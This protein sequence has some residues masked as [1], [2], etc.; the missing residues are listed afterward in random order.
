MTSFSTKAD[1]C[2]L[3]VYCNSFPL[4]TTQEYILQQPS[5]R[6]KICL[7]SLLISIHQ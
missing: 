5:Y 6:E 7:V 3:E 1:S 4:A 2:Q